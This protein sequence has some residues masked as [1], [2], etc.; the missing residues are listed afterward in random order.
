M[1]TLDDQ[2]EFEAQL[3]NSLKY[4]SK[5]PGISFRYLFELSL[6]AAGMLTLYLLY[7]GLL[8]LVVYGVWY[9]ATNF[10]HLLA[11][12]IGSWML[13]IGPIAVGGLTAF[14][15]AK[16]LFARRSCLEPEEGLTE[17][18]HPLL[19]ALVKSLAE[20]TQTP[21]PNRISIGLYTNA[22]AV[23]YRVNGNKE[24]VLAIGLPVIASMNVQ[25]L[26]GIIAHEL[27]HL[28]QRGGMQ[29]WHWSNFVVD[30]FDYVA[31]K[32][33]RWDELFDAWTEKH[34]HSRLGVVFHAAFWFRLTSRAAAFVLWVAA[35]PIVKCMSR[36]MEF[37]A[38]RF[39]VYV[40][41]SDEFA[42]TL[43]RMEL[44]QAAQLLATESTQQ[45]W[46]DG[47][48]AEDMCEL[49][50]KR[51]EDVLTDAELV[52]KCRE[53]LLREPTGWFDTHPGGRARIACAEREALA[54][55][56]TSERPA[57]ELLNDFEKLCR[58][59]TRQYYRDE[60]QIDL[61]DAETITAERLL[62]QQRDIDNSCETLARFLQTYVLIG[63]QRVFLPIKALSAQLDASLLRE[64]LREARHA[65]LE[66]FE[67][68]KG[69]LES[70][71]WAESCRKSL[72]Q[73]RMMI[74]SN[75]EFDADELGLPSSKRNEIEKE[76]QRL[77]QLAAQNRKAIAK[78]EELASARFVASL[79][80][81]RTTAY[82]E[83]ADAVLP[84]DEVDEI[85]T[86]LSQLRELWPDFQACEVAGG[87]LSC[88][89]NSATYN[90]YLDSFA[91]TLEYRAGHA[92]QL[93]AEMYSAL[94]DMR[95]PLDHARGELTLAEFAVGEK[96]PEG[97]D[98][99][100]VARSIEMMT[101][102]LR[103][104]YFRLFAKLGMVAE[105]ME[106][107]TGLP[108]LPEATNIGDKYDAYS[109]T[110]SV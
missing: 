110:L 78:L 58:E 19:F 41:G 66:E 4:S 13:F 28:S 52:Q 70:F 34:R 46:H 85:I 80:L 59:R 18:D 25:Q 57:T 71:W 45:A 86:C 53:E 21:C 51:L 15:L 47:R 99:N 109:E 14:F 22:F 84:A 9:Y 60:L 5:P 17:Q 8:G 79:A 27:G 104:L 40:C 42:N 30:W 81:S 108:R 24:L 54:P 56:I 23:R 44:L 77:R 73:A 26:A 10:H 49:Y 89:L 20:Y 96:L 36:R 75:L 16:P 98:M 69:Q 105:E 62:E 7:L 88:L 95:F 76:H 90:C 6:T 100:G 50:L 37:D 39:H 65:Y 32:R 61:G 3:I 2:E 67:A 83:Q 38:D 103:N 107:C 55:A 35:Q 82:G 11:G 64:E 68:K 31:F 92:E 91:G 97:G 101:E 94:S 1:R 33:D 72:R 93:L 87:H 74:K 29:L 63:L 102:R 43:L 12:G 48:L 106:T